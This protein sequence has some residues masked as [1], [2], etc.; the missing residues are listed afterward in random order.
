LDINNLKNYRPVSN[1]S[2]LSKIIEKVVQQQLFAYLN[3]HSLLPE[4]QSAYR[5][6]H[7]TET[8]LVKVVND[9]LRSMDKGNVSV[10]TLL[11]LSSAFDTIDHEILLE[12]LS[13]LYGISGDVLSWFHSYLSDRT[14]F[15][16]INDTTSAASPLTFGVPQGSVL[17]PILFIMYTNPLSTLIKSHSIDSQSFADDTQLHKSCSPEQ[18]KLSIDTLQE[19]I[20]D[21]KRWMT[22]N[23]LKLND[24]KTEVILVKSKWC[25]DVDDALNSVKIG[26]TDIPFVE[27]ARDLG[28]IVSGDELSLDIHEHTK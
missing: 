13:S 25:T 14:Q 8:A 21:I 7:S 15:V 11:D 2:F 5:P 19:C 27:S 16:T 28:F 12:R 24:S 26:D 17:G 22:E 23:K 9:L 6:F 1:L 3:T 4:C 18:L 10:L 20:V